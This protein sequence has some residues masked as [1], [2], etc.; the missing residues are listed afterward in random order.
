[1][2]YILNRLKEAST[3]Q[4]IIVF[5]AGVAHYTLPPDVQQYIVG[6]AVFLFTGAGFAKKEAK[7]PDAVVS[8]AAVSNG[9]SA[10]AS[11]EIKA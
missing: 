9:K 3:W 8:P 1:M 11:G 4:A 5:L 7:S 2:D 6:I 10:V